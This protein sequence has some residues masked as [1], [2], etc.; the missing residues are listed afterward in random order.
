MPVIYPLEITSSRFFGVPSAHLMFWMLE[1]KR[2][3]HLY[4]KLSYEP[5]NA[6]DSRVQTI[7]PNCHDVYFS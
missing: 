1:S 5:L 6:I 3:V 2:F 7:A 4:M